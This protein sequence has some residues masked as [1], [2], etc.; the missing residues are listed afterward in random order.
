MSFYDEEIL[1]LRNILL[2]KSN[3]KK[4]KKLFK[5]TKELW[6]QEKRSKIFEIVIQNYKRE[7]ISY[8]K[9]EK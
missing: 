5:E 8:F 2:N 6:K 7:L 3:E 9:E 1:R 4:V